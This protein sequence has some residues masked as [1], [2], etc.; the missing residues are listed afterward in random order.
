MNPLTTEWVNKAEGDFLTARRE[1]R[2]RVAPNFDGVCFHAQQLA[3]KYLKA[4]LQENGQYIP[5]TH[6]L[7]DLLALCIRLDS[8]FQSLQPNLNVLEGYAV[9]FRYPGQS[10]SVLEAKAAFKA[11][12]SVR[13]F[14]RHK[15]DAEKG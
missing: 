5:R 11:A 9:Q 3:E 8:S 6:I 12:E 15:L 13:A 14:V 4:V 2:V 7:A 10:A 1:L